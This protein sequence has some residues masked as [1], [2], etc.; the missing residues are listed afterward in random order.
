MVFCFTLVLQWNLCRQSC[1]FLRNLKKLQICCYINGFLCVLYF[2]LFYFC[3]FLITACCRILVKTSL[4]LHKSS[5]FNNLFVFALCLPCLLRFTVLQV[6]QNH[7]F[8]KPKT[9]LCFLLF[10]EQCVSHCIYNDKL[11]FVKSM[12]LSLSQIAYI[13]LP[14]MSNTHNDEKHHF[15]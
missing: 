12:K 13:S 2:A 3:V 5:F 15:L 9:T 6:L 11:M 14:R 10:F 1:L 7:C 4:K 8:Y